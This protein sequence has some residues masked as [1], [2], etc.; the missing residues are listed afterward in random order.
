M[1]V[2]GPD[3]SFHG[4]REGSSEEMVPNGDRKNLLRVARVGDRE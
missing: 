4:I 2:G 1:G 3:C